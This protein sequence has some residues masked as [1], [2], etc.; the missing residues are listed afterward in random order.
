[1]WF[2]CSMKIQI[3]WYYVNFAKTD[4]RACC[5]VALLV[6]TKY[7]FVVQLTKKVSFL[8]FW[9]SSAGNLFLILWPSPC[10]SL[11][12]SSVKDFSSSFPL[13]LGSQH[14]KREMSHSCVFSWEKLSMIFFWSVERWCLIL[15]ITLSPG[16][17]V[18]WRTRPQ[19]FVNLQSENWKKGYLITI[20]S[21]LGELFFCLYTYWKKNQS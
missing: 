4:L 1:M 9:F 8:N 7:L 11:S 5:T 21:N 3:R 19:I 18:P 6:L 17:L 16:S 10:S 12:P 13:T 14:F 20:W 2:R 15:S